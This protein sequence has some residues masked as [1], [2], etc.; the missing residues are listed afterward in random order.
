MLKFEDSKFP[1]EKMTQGWY[2]IGDRLFTR[3]L[4]ALIYASKTKEEITWDFN[5]NIFS[6]QCTMPRLDISLKE[7]Y[8]QRALQLREKYDYLILAY[9]GGAD[10]DTILHAFIDNNIPIDEVWC[11]WPTTLLEIRKYEL[12]Y[13]KESNN[14]ASEWP[15]VIKPSLD[16]LRISNPEIKIHLSDCFEN[17]TEE[18][19][20]DTFSVV[21]IPSNYIST[22]RF[23]YIQEYVYTLPRNESAAVIYG[24]DK[25]IPYRLGNEY[26]FV[27]SDSS[28]FTKSDEIKGKRHNIESFFWTPNFPSIVVQQAHRV[29]DYLKLNPVFMEERFKTQ[30]TY[31]M[32]REKSFDKVIKQICYPD[33]DMSKHQV[34]KSRHVYNMQFINHLLPYTQEHFHQSWDSALR[35]IFDCLDPSIA[36][37]NG[38]NLIEDT[39][40]FYNF[41]RIGYLS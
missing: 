4:E 24:I 3:K 11:D 34:D 21:S 26:G 25:C 5:K 14:M 22:K 39:K 13:S 37:Q 29:W 27:F 17:P 9:S 31:W 38:Q 41:H 10:S 19:R 2:V 33:W 28:V 7:M 8:H 36:F 20:E 1:V 18:D 16:A 12:S 23:R 32:D 30:K 15:L 6:H 35:N 40:V